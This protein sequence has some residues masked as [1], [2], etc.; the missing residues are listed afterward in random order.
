MLWIITEHP[1]NQKCHLVKVTWIYLVQRA[2]RMTTRINDMQAIARYWFANWAA[3]RTIALDLDPLAHGRTR[4]A[5]SLTRRAI[6]NPSA[7][8]T[9]S[10][11]IRSKTCWK[12][13]L[14]IIR[15][16]SRRVKP[17]AW[18]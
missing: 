11:V 18:A 2:V 16:A 9:L 17:R 6:A 3:V 15:V 8:R 7:S 10:I 14:T 12:K 4:Y 5:Y 1:P 13:P